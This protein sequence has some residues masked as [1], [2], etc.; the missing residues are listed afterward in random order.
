MDLKSIDEIRQQWNVVLKKIEDQ[1]G[2]DPDL[3]GVL[4][5]IGVQE[6]GQGSRSFSK[7]EKQDLMHIATC[8]LLSYYGYYIL[9]GQD[10][11]GWPHWE[12]VEK[13]PNLSLKE[14]DIILKKS[15]IRYF[16]EN[17]FI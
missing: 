13:I 14:Q 12:L 4:F 8:R 3:Q 1:F 16:K 5:I 9:K 11:E 10:E 6:L 15:V 7:N 2:V 17:N